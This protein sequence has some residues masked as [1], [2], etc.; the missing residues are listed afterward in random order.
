MMTVAANDLSTSAEERLK[1]G[2]QLRADFALMVQLAACR[3]ASPAGSAF[4][5]QTLLPILPRKT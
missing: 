2:K 4:L 5:P 3:F 1:A